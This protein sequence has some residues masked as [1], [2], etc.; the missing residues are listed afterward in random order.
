ML[1]GE[2]V[3]LN[4]RLRVYSVVLRWCRSPHVSEW[5]MLQKTS[6]MCRVQLLEGCESSVPSSLG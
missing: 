1:L 6:D 4:Q 2:Q 5:P 3:C